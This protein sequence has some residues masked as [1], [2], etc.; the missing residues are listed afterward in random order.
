MPAGS[1]QALQQGGAFPERSAGLVG[2]GADVGTDAGLV[3]LEGCP[4]DVAGVM[5]HDQ[6][7]PTRRVRRA[8]FWTRAAAGLVDE[9]LVSCAAIDIGASVGRMREHAVDRVDRW[10]PPRPARARDPRRLTATGTTAPRRAATA[11]RPA[12]SRTRRTARRRRNDAT[13]RLVGV[14]EDLAF[15]LAPNEP[16][17]Q[18]PAQLTSSGFVADAARSRARSTCS[19]ASLIVPFKPEQQPVVE[20]SRDRRTPSSSAIKRVGDP[21]EI[22]K[23]IPV[24]AVAGETADLQANHDSDVPEGDLGGEAGEAASLDGPRAGEPEVLV[25]DG[26][27]I[28]GQPSATARSTSA[29]WRSVDSGFVPAGRLVDWRT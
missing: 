16:D 11:T 5:I 15:A 6:D 24:R 28:A 26:H 9:T 19:S 1:D 20:A 25:D 3:G 27:R 2:L 10:V 14:E 29:Y 18:A 7:L 17:R 22:E 23:P 8:R 13:H 4:V 12:P 21:A